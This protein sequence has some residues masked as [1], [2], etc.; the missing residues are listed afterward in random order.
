MLKHTS[1]DLVDIVNSV[2]K[3]PSQK[4]HLKKGELKVGYDADIVIFDEKFSIITTIINGEVKYS[5]LDY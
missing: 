4:L 5:C 1:M 3:I 2:T